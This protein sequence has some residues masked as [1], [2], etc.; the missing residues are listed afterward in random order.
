MQ[1]KAK[2]KNGKEQQERKPT[3]TMVSSATVNF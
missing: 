1:A 2:E 3:M